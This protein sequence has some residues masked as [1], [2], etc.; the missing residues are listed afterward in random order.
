M[1]IKC[2]LLAAAATLCGFSGLHAQNS[3]MSPYSAIGYGQLLDHA[4]STQASMGGVGYAMH[5]GRQI[6]VMNPASYAR[7]DSLT[8]LFDMGFEAKAAW[9]SETDRNG[10]VNRGS[11]LG[12]GLGYITMQFPLAKRLGMSVGLLPWS[13]VGYAYDGDIKNGTLG[14][15]GEGSINEAYAGL[16]LRLVGGL[17]VGANMGYL[18]GATNNYSYGTAD[19]GAV[20]LYRDELR[21]RDYNVNTALLYV[22]PIGSDVVSLGLTYQLPKAL[23]GHLYKYSQ[24]LPQEKEQKLTDDIRL[25]DGYDIPASYGAGISYTRGGNFTV[26]VDGTF[27]PWSQARFGG[28]T[29]VFNDRVKLAAGLQWRPA[30]RGSYWQRVEYRLGAFTQRDYIKVRDNDIDQ[31]GVTVGA[32]FPIPGFKSTVNVGLEWLNRRG[33]PDA[34]VKENYLNLRIGV[35]FNES[36]FRKA[37]IY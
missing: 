32:G 27:Q 20:S 7:V 31:I 8:F 11:D 37:K 35:N 29:G 17:S 30:P 21:V 2:L 23:R 19:N 3:T 15:S 1:K 18:F 25:E 12:G 13:Q 9:M 6:N 10:N 14:R 22:Q 26:E 28:E 24:A 33:N 5:S 16:G 4:T 34:L 36:W